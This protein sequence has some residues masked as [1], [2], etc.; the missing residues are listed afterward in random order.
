MTCSHSARAWKRTWTA[1]ANR[2]TSPTSTGTTRRTTS[3]TS[4]TSSRSSVGAVPGRAAPTLWCSSTGFLWRSSSASAP[5]SKVLSTRRSASTCATTAR[6]RF[7]SCS[8]RRNSSWRCRRTPP[9]TAPPPPTGSSGRCGG[10]KP[11]ARKTPSYR[12]S[13]TR[14]RP[15]KSATLCSRGATPITGGTWTSCGT[16]ERGRLPLRTARCTACCA[17]SGF[18]SLSG[19]LSSST[20][21]R[22]K[23]PTTSSSLL[24]KRPSSG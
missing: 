18:W 13:S 14:R 3:F 20:L 12:D 19:A 1:T 8:A 9:V 24:S 22:R 15:R 6:T 4:R 10:R 11:R 5:T 21:G 17:P 7:P 16:R 23:L 2:M